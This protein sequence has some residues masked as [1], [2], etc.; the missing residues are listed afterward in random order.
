MATP[1]VDGLDWE[2]D[3]VHI[4][5]PSHWRQ[6]QE[7]TYGDIHSIISTIWEFTDY[8]LAMGEPTMKMCSILVT[9][10]PSA[11]GAQTMWLKFEA[12]RIRDEGPGLGVGG[13]MNVT[14]M[15]RGMSDQ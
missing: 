2:R 1:Y 7:L 8:W 4:G 5:V 6:G 9:K 13:A 3:G 12:S 14:E 10:N 15:R 11:F